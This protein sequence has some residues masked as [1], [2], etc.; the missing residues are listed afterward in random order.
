MTQTFK[1]INVQVKLYPH[2]FEGLGVYNG[3]DD[4]Y[5]FNWNNVACYEY[6][7]DNFFTISNRNVKTI[8]DARLLI[9]KFNENFGLEWGLDRFRLECTSEIKF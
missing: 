8:E 1:N 9:E 4:L 3:Y 6:G 2:D 5:C 7:D